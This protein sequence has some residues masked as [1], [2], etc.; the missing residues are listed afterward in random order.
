[1]SDRAVI[2]I[3]DDNNDSVFL[4]DRAFEKANV[5]NPRIVVQNGKEAIDYLSGEG[6]YADREKYPWP[7][8]MLLD[9]K[10]PLLDGF[11]VLRWWRGR[12][13]AG[14]LPIVVMSSSNQDVDVA[15]AIEL[16]AAAYHVKPADF[17]YLV[18]VARELSERWLHP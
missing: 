11:D 18:D 13:G 3:A 7:A 10:M 12:D 16:G 15:K 5:R 6:V 9:L 1:M 8:L 4:L 2:L 14:T 17:G